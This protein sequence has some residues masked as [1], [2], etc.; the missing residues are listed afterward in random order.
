MLEQTSHCS[1]LG[2]RPGN[3]CIQLT[4]QCG[5]R[6]QLTCSFVFWVSIC[7]FSCVSICHKDEQQDL[8]FLQTRKERPLAEMMDSSEPT[9]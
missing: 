1:L 7:I 5:G 4:V 8:L 6:G 2:D 9:C 3:S